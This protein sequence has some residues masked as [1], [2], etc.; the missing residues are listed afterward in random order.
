MKKSLRLLILEDSENDALLLV[1]EV[2]RGGYDPQWERMDTPAQLADALTHKDWDIILCDYSM[3]QFNALKALEMVREKGLD[4]PFIIVSGTIGEDVAV[5]AMKAGAHDYLMKGKLKRLLPAIERELRDAKIRQKRRLMVEKHQE[6]EK[7]FKDLVAMLPQTIFEMDINGNLTFANTTAYQMFGYTKEDLQKGLNALQMF[8]PDDRERVLRDI[9][10]QIR[11]GIGKGKEYTALR[12]DGSTFPVITYSSLIKRNDEVI[13]LRG[14]VVDIT[15]HKQTELEHRTFANL[16]L[17]LVNAES[18]ETFARILKDATLELFSWDAFYIAE[19]VKGTKTFKIVHTVDTID[20]KKVSIDELKEGPVELKLLPQVATGQCYLWNRE[21]GEETILPRF[22]DTSRPSASLMFVQ[23]TVGEELLGVLSVQSYQPNR[24]T[25]K[26]LALLKSLMDHAAPAM[27]RIQVEQE[28]RDTNRRLEETL[29][30]L[31]DTQKQIVQ[32]ER[33]AAVGELAAGIAHDFNNMLQGIS[34]YVE[35]ALLE[36]DVKESTAKHLNNIFSLVDH[37]TRLIR[38]ILD[39]SRK[40]IMESIHLSLGSY[41]KEA[42]NLLQR[43]I[44]ENIKLRFIASP[45][46]DWV[47]G[48]PTRI[49][50]AIMNLV[51]NARDAMPDGGELKIAISPFITEADK[52]APYPS[53]PASQWVMVEVTDTGCGIP[54]ENL[55]RIFAPFFTTKERGK[56]TGLGLSQVYGIVKQHGGYITADSEVG[57]GTKF[58]IYLPSFK[59]VKDEGEEA[60]MGLQRGK[61]ELILLA[62]DDPTVLLVNQARLEYLG[63]RVLTATDG[64]KALEIFDQSKGTIDLVI[65]DIVMPEIEGIT[66]F[67][68]LQKRSPNVKMVLVTGY[69][70]EGNQEIMNL[71]VKIIQKPFGKEKL[72]QVVRQA[73]DGS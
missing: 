27:R 20:G 48:D 6:S 8:I 19:R 7:R 70:M 38:Q 46:S 5:N 26:D 9:Q 59:E 16:A 60:S 25:E 14:M 30:N 10:T 17:N 69:P 29:V 41:I 33:L 47:Y 22:G 35:L 53:M 65:S 21:P 40:A 55:P 4:I 37:A 23:I 36:T 2:E 12:K 39:F 68:E 64:K 51:I 31:Q 32:Q 71:G 73:I 61:N 44:P 58:A 1:R 67:R 45:G 15:E 11:E 28:L 54:P 3:P 56:G 66:L 34:G 43:I 42:I 49:E 50:Q 57:K 63:Y 13:G 52:P 24:Y 72:S 62:E 18:P